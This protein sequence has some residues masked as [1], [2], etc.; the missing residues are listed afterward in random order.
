MHQ[1]R[2]N[3]GILHIEVVVWTIDIGWHNTSEHASM[4]LVISPAQTTTV[5]VNIS[6]RSYLKN[7]LIA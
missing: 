3:M 2:D 5:R 4:L 6:F 7:M 1:S